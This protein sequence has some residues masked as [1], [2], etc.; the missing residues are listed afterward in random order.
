MFATKGPRFGFLIRVIASNIGERTGKCHPP[1][2]KPCL[3][4]LKPTN[5]GNAE[6]APSLCLHTKRNDDECLAAVY[7]PTG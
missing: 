2:I 3:T 7:S 5:L 6:M 1:R 4:E